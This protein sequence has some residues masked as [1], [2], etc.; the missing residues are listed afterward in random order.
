VAKAETLRRPFLSRVLE[1][2]P[3]LPVERDSLAALKKLT[4]EVTQRRK[5]GWIPRLVVFPEGTRSDDG[6]LQPFK[7]GP[8]LLAAHLG[9]PVLPVILRGTFA[10]HKKNAFMVYPGRVQVDIGSP[11]VPPALTASGPRRDLAAVDAAAMLLD[12]TRAIFH[13]VPEIAPAPAKVRA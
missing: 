13:A 10:I 11:L 5:S 3:W 1:A 7:I 8:F 12:K 6:R 9:V 2:L 4:E